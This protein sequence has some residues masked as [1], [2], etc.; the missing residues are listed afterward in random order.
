MVFIGLC[1]RHG[2]AFFAFDIDVSVV[3]VGYCGDT[4]AAAASGQVEAIEAV[5]PLVHG[6]LV[7]GAH[8]GL[9]AIYV[10]RV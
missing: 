1:V 7:D 9:C 8:Y 2:V 3:A 10:G 4:V 6:P 5:G